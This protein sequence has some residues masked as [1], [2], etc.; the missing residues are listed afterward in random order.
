MEL[1]SLLAPFRGQGRTALL[2][3]LHAVQESLGWIPPEAAQAVA[4]ALS[5]P[6]ADVYGVVTFYAMFYERPAGRTIIRICKGPLCA[7]RGSRVLLE[8]LKRRLNVDEGEPTEDGSWMVEFV[9]CLGLCEH[10]PAVLVGTEAFGPVTNLQD[11]EALLE[12]RLARPQPRVGGPVRRLTAHLNGGRLSLADYRN[13]GGYEALAGALNTMTPKDVREAV[14]ASGLWGRGGAAFPTGRKWEL[15]AQAD[16]EPKYVVCNADE[17]EPGTFKDRVLLETNPHLILEGLIL[18]AYAIGASKGF[19]YLRGEYGQAYESVQ[20]ALE[21]A[22]QAGLLGEHILGTDFSF[23]IELRRGAGAYICG[24]ETALFESIEGKRGYPRLKPPYPTTHGLFGK[25]TAIN[26]VETLANVPLIVREGPEAY[27]AYG[28]EDSPGTK[29]FSISGDVARPGVYEAPFGITLR[30]L[31]ETW[32]GGVIGDLAAVL[33][34][35]AAGAFVAP[36]DLDWPLTLEEGRKRGVPVGT[37]TVMVFNRERNL[38]S[39]L[40]NLAEFFAEESCG[41]CFPCQ[42]GTQRQLDILQR[43][44]QGLGRPADLVVLQDIGHTMAE[45]S[46]CGLGQTASM[47][48]MSALHLWPHLFR[49]HAS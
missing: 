38:Q 1:D 29:L 5:V 43:L 44:V 21:E 9:P 6:L 8:N 11:V 41:K 23:D 24:E 15:A 45:A 35:G 25:P 7:M 32:A 22:R 12:Q 31:L 49:N 27:R 34:G 20:R 28:T 42:L 4:R 26:N 36:D 37:G 19:L 39:L 18:A 10:A 16:G 3:A 48:L 40:L 2:P 13:Q 30:E 33:V 17:S 46:I 14:K 47:A